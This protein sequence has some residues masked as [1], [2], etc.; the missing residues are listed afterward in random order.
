VVGGPDVV[1]THL[2]V[3]VAV[4]LSQPVYRQLSTVKLVGYN[5]SSMLSTL[6]ARL[7]RNRCVSGIVQIQR[8]PLI[9]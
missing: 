5:M 7:R 2:W 4:Q 3:P 1:R 9:E 6:T 8:G